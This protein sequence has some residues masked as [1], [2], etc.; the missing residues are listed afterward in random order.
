MMDED[1]RSYDMWLSLVKNEGNIDRIPF[2][3]SQVSGYLLQ[4]ALSWANAGVTEPED[5]AFRLHWFFY[6]PS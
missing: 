4:A 1:L 6:V 3:W 2:A 5:G